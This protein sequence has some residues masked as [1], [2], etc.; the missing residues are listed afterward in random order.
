MSASASASA[1]AYELIFFDPLRG[2]PDIYDFSIFL[3]DER[4]RLEIMESFK[5]LTGHYVARSRRQAWRSIIKF[6]EFLSDS[7]VSA[8]C[9]P[10]N[11]LLSDFYS[12]SKTSG[13][14]DKTIGSHYNFVRRT[15]IWLSENGD[16]EIWRDQK[17][18]K[19]TI[20]RE[21]KNYRANDLDSRDLKKISEL[22]K[23][24]VTDAKKRFL[25]RERISNE[26]EVSDFE[27]SEYEKEALRRLIES[28]KLGLWTQ[29]EFK[30]K[31]LCHA[32]LRK[33]A[34]FRELTYQDAV[35]ILLL[36]MIQTAGNPLAIMELKTNCIE[37]HPFDSE[38]CVVVWSKGR[39]AREQSKSFLRKGQYGVPEL[40]K[41][42]LEMTSP[43]RHLASDSDKEMLFITRN[44]NRAARISVQ[45]IHN[46]LER[47][48]IDN[49]LSKFS[50]ADIRKAVAGV[51]LKNTGSVLEVA[52]LLQHKNIRTTDLYLQGREAQ[53]KQYENLYT[54]QGE[55]LKL[56]SVATF[57][58]EPEETIFGFGCKDSESGAAK[59][60][61][62]GQVCVQF[63]SCATC[64]NA[65]I[66][67]D[68]PN[69][70]ARILRSRNSL[71]DFKQRALVDSD[72]QVRFDS[73]CAPI[74]KIINDEILPSVN[75]KTL[76]E[77]ESICKGLP[78][79]PVVY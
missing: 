56:S 69:Y 33:L 35:P 58:I 10:G 2:R 41:L 70:I 11:D 36:I 57:K 23:K 6:M 77:A 65:L 43:I 48:R 50:F 76:L 75:K 3:V 60:S 20:Y 44:G 16:M 71:L 7:N 8:D 63:L 28:E 45:G 31:V 68:D 15:L 66:V 19:K 14:L 39:A 52:S 1:S 26:L 46:A 42:V 74:L 51:V 18:G 79:I 34:R 73:I 38:R 49:D 12:H 13:I 55:M 47:F 62:K 30:G 22:C 53:E 67:I 78:R 40:I 54:Y 25:L 59:G 4:L 72:Y 32:P 27:L 5:S 37:D 17:I 9:K 61:V 29:R 21:S 24:N 64:P